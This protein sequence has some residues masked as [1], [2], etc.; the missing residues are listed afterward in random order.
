MPS[1]ALLD[2]VEAVLPTAGSGLALREVAALVT[3][4]GYEAVRAAARGLIQE[5]RAVATGARSHL[6]YRR[7]DGNL[8]DPGADCDATDARDEIAPRPLAGA[9]HPPN[10]DLGPA[11]NFLERCGFRV[12]R[13]PETGAYVVG[14]QRL[15]PAQIVRQA[16]VLL[17]RQLIAG[18]GMPP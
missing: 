7:V 15:N 11:L 13:N 8:P 6:R 18:R 17:A 4:W 2:A 16:N 3:G 1:A 9:P 14:G 12:V 10:V 5:D